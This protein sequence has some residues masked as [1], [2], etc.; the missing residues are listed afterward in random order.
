MTRNDPST[1]AAADAGRLGWLD[2]TRLHGLFA[3]LVGLAQLPLVLGLALGRS[4][5]A[6]VVGSGGVL[7]VSVGTNLLRGRP[8]FYSRW[9]ADGKP[10]AVSTAILAGLTVAVVA[11]SVA[12]SLP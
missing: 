10:G 6:F 4:L 2:R 11:A 7:L 12:A 8:A 5:S 9:R 1:A 3:V